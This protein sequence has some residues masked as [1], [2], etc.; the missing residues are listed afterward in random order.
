[1]GGSELLSGS[2][3]SLLHPGPEPGCLALRG[4]GREG[5]PPDVVS[6]RCLTLA[7]LMDS[8]ISPGPLSADG[9]SGRRWQVKNT[10]LA[11]RLRCGPCHENYSD[12]K[13]L[14]QEISNGTK[15]AGPSA[16]LLPPT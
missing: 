16:S 13:P 8:V 5:A 7:A 2:R 10:L 1:M 6:R 11:K 4:S 3:W 15:G 14:R 12:Q 9:Q